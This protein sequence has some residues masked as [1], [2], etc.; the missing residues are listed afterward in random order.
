MD[1]YEQTEWVWIQK[2][3]P[4]RWASGK[5]KKKKK[6]SCIS[7]LS[8]HVIPSASSGAFSSTKSRTA[9]EKACLTPAESGIYICWEAQIWVLQIR[10]RLKRKNGD[11]SCQSR[12]YLLLWVLLWLP[13][14]RRTGRDETWEREEE[15]KRKKNNSSEMRKCFGT[16]LWHQRG[17]MRR[18]TNC[19]HM[20]PHSVTTEQGEFLT[21]WL[22][23]LSWK[24]SGRLWLAI[25][26]PA[27]LD[28]S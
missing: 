2:V 19:S 28:V 20:K 4:K 14:N 1:K 11:Q 26:K 21:F 7:L 22:F 3:K 10:R 15:G 23:W 16:G 6:N 27:L 8:V 9:V 25:Q 12:L 5:K 13:F 18:V 24:R 17:A